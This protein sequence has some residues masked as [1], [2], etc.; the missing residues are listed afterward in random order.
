M[1]AR[2][3][4]PT[5]LWACAALRVA[6]LMFV[7]ALCLPCAPRAATPQMEAALEAAGRA[8]APRAKAQKAAS[9]KAAGG[10]R[11]AK[12]RAA[13]KGDAPGAATANVY[14]GQP[15]VTEKELLAFADLLPQFR[16]W[17][18]AGQEEA[19]PVVRDGKADFLYS[20]NAAA[21]VTA[22]G[23]QPARFF[24]VMGRLAAALVIVEEGNDMGSRP[25]DMPSVTNEELALTRRHIGTLLTAG[26]DAPP[27]RP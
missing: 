22:K 14:A 24:C 1:T 9:G 26:G 18:R 13:A 20:P 3:L 8:P 23:W 10:G 2:T 21:W 16:A 4:L 25:A 12:S 17:A 19:H 7:I 27:I 11:A 15:A 5:R 6:A